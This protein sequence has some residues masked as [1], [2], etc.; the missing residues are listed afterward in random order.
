MYLFL[1]NLCFNG[2]IGSSAFYPKILFDILLDTHVITYNGCLT[3]IFLTVFYIYFECTNLTVMAY[4]RYV[5]ICKPL[6]YHSIMTIRKV[7]TLIFLTLLLSCLECSIGLV[8]LARLPLCGVDIDKLYCS[9]WAV[10]KLS[11]VD[12]ILN[13]NYSIIE[14]DL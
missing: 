8:L 14:S 1:C 12:T 7:W 4:D 5:A 9:N 6:H 2:I 11:C 3:Q 10:L 13:N